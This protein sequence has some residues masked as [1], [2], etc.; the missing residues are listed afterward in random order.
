MKC[1]CNS[2]QWMYGQDDECRL[3]WLCI[4][5]GGEAPFINPSEIQKIE[6]ERLNI[7]ER[8]KAIIKHKNKQIK[9]LTRNLEKTQYE[10][11]FL[12]EY[13]ANQT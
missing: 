1:N 11:H 9:I 10:I 12:K 6:S 5:C 13:H 4:K 8:A 7:E 2:P 3:F